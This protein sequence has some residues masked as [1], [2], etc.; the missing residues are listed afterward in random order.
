M[1]KSNGG[2]SR[3]PDAVPELST[4]YFCGIPVYR[5]ASYVTSKME[6]VYWHASRTSWRR[7]I[8]TLLLPCITLLM[9]QN[10]EVNSTSGL[11]LISFRKILIQYNRQQDDNMSELGPS[12]SLPSG[13]H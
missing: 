2:A 9:S 1:C 8:L 12:F 7:D 10:C 11:I 3:T 4:V 5:E 6:S 13:R